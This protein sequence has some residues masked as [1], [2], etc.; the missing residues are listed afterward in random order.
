MT[1]VMQLVVRPDGQMRCVY[2]EELNL[3]ELGEVTVRRASN[4]EPDGQGRW[5]ADLGLVGG[6]QLGP[7]CRRSDALRAEVA[8][9]AERWLVPH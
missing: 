7:F 6:P 4:V 3:A 8:W 2:G 5:R 1:D 9:L